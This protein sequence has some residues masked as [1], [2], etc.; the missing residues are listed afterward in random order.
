MNAIPTVVP[1]A[2]DIT[3]VR[4]GLLI[5]LATP[6]RPG[7][8]RRTRRGPSHCTTIGAIAA[9]SIEIAAEVTPKA[10]GASEACHG[11]SAPLLAAITHALIPSTATAAHNTARRVVTTFDVSSRSSRFD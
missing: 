3:A 4:P 7:A 2:T 5:R 8:L 9:E 1:S 6:R 10:T 11:S